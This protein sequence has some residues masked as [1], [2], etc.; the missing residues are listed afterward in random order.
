MPY[1]SPKLGLVINNNVFVSYDFVKAIIE[2]K[3]IKKIKKQFLIN[4]FLIWS[5]LRR[6]LFNKPIIPIILFRIYFS[7]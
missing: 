7:P 5:M 6:K 1:N 4:R 2:N 3:D